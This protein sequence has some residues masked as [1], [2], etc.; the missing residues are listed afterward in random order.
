[1]SDIDHLFKQ[2][3]I[4]Q[5]GRSLIDLS[6]SERQ[7]LD[8]NGYVLSKLFDDI[9]LIEL[10]DEDDNGNIQR[11]GIFVPTNNTIKTWRK[12]KVVLKGRNADQCEINDIVIFPHDKGSS[13][14]NVKVKNYGIIKKGMFLNQ[15]RIF[16]VCDLDN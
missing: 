15:E 7:C 3:G 12:G 11:D 13:V 1:M 5:G 9:I 8:F 16:G 6:S 4:E 10:I 2:H 14:T